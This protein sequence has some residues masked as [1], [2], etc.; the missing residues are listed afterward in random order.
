MAGAIEG[1]R[2]SLLGSGAPPVGMILASAST[3][4]AVLV[5]GAY[6]FRRMERSFADVV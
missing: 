5:G 3:A 1:I 2:W 4:V 6:F